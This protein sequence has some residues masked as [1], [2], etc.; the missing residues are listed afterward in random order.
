MRRS[1]LFIVLAISGCDALSARRTA[2]EGVER[3]RAGKYED[4]LGHFD[5][6]IAGEPDMATL[7]LNRGFTCL[8]LF[9]AGVKE[10]R[11]KYGACAIEAFRTYQTLKSDDPRG[12]DYLLQSFVDTL[13]YAD[14]ESYFAADLAKTPPSSE[15]M[16]LL[17]QIAAKRGDVDL[18]QKWCKKRAEATPKDPAAHQC[19]GTLVWD[20]L[21][22]HPEIT[23][24]KR[25][26]MAD[27]GIAALT[28]SID[29][30]PEVPEPY[31]FANLLHRERALGH[32]ATSTDTAIPTASAAPIIVNT[33]AELAVLKA[34]EDA[35]A[36]DI[37]EADR[38]RAL[39]TEKARTAAPVTPPPKGG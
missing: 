38:L 37:A 11:E 33:D 31:T 19:L 22:R 13:R 25:L 14:A 3:Y 12:R 10:E 27:E 23:G 35:R 17:G 29:L 9:K 32:C 39:A 8:Q 18:A 20:H 4:A 6:A 2:Q 36:A 15:A 30:A 1:A 21:H 24:D 7:H 16:A 26:A 34:C 28:R 5:L